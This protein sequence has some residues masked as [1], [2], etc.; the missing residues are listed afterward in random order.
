MTYAMV[1]LRSPAAIPSAA[2]RAAPCQKMS[3]TAAT[4]APA[5]IRKGTVRTV[6]RQHA[7]RLPTPTDHH[8]PVSPPPAHPRPPPAGSPRPVP[9]GHRPQADAP[10]HDGPYLR[11]P[12]PSTGHA[13]PLPS[14]ATILQLFFFQAEDGI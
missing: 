1:M 7:V 9:P 10:A 14:V 4:P 2:V 12:R 3:I 11:L 8:A 6:S 13:L 5:A